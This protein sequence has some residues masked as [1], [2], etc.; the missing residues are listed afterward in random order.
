MGAKAAE[1]LIAE[2]FIWSFGKKIRR[3]LL[4]R[5]SVLEVSFGNRVKKSSDEDNRDEEEAVRVAQGKKMRA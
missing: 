2:S 1:A 3:N 5:I 4:L